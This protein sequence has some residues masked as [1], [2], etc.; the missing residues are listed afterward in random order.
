MT[1][2]T[3]EALRAELETQ[4][5]I[6]YLWW[7][8]TPVW[9]RLEVSRFPNQNDAAFPVYASPPRDPACK[10]PTCHS[11]EYQQALADDVAGQLVGK[12]PTDW[13]AS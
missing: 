11:V 8:D 1:Q 5:P 9:K 6:A 4:E 7:V 2:P 10:C 3:N 13:A 12:E